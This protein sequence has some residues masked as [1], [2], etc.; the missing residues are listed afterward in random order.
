M[1]DVGCRTSVDIVGSVISTAPAAPLQATA[2]AVRLVRSVAAA[3][4]CV[5]AAAAGHHQAGGALPAAAVIAVFAGSAIIAWVLSARRIT[6]GQLVG[7]LVLCQV[8]V[9]LTASASDMVMGPGM[10]VGHVVATGFSVVVLARGERFAWQLAE[11]LALRVAPLIR[12][13]AVVAARR[14]AL[15][16][17]ITRTLH[18]ICLTCSRP[19]RGPPV[20]SA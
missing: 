12:A 9:H 16:V 10:L 1:P 2:P 20:A 7:L 11:R 3:L 8:G 5:S 19:L 6:S 18:D 17:V 14:V 15:P 4:V 13:F